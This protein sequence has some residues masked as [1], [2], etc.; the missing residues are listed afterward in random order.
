M[1]SKAFCFEK[2]EIMHHVSKIAVIILVD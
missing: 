1:K 2:V